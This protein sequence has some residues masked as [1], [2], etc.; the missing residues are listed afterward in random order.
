[1]RSATHL[2]HT[3]AARMRMTVTQ[4]GHWTIMAKEEEKGTERVRKRKQTQKKGNQD[5]EGD[6]STVTT[7]DETQA[8]DAIAG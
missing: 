5:C 6:L 8:D 1:M 2:P 3:T 4:S 7:R